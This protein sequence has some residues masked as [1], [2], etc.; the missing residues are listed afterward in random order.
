ML[1]C[2]EV[3]LISLNKPFRRWVVTAGLGGVI[4]AIAGLAF[5][6]GD[7][8]DSTPC[9]TPVDHPEWT[10]ARR[11]NEAL[12]NAIRRDVPAPTVH[13]RNLFHISA[14]MWDAW[15]AYDDDA[16]GYFV[17]E[18]L[19]AADVAAARDEAISYAAFRVLESRYLLSI[20][21]EATITEIDAL[22][23]TLCYSREVTT[24]EGDRPAA[25]G[26]RIGS[27]ILAAGLIDGA[28]EADGYLDPDYQ[29]VNPPLEVTESGTTLIDPNRWQP[30][31]LE[32]MISQNGIP[33]ENGVQEF[34]DSHWGYVTGFALPVAGPDGVP[35]DPGDPPYLGDP[36]SDQAFKDS[37]IEVI[38]YSSLL[39]PAGGVSIDISP[40]ALGANPLGTYDGNGLDVN[41]VTGTPYAPNIVNQ[42]DFGRVLA[43]FWADGPDSETPPGHWNTLANSI[44][45]DRG[46][47][48]RIGGAGEPV[49]R[50]EW[51]VKLY[52]AL[53]GANH[54]AAVAAWGTKGHYDYVRPISM[55][56]YM[57][58]L[59]QSS[60]PAGAS[61]H[62]DGLPL[63]AGLVEVVTAETTAPGQRHAALAGAEGQIAIR[64]W[65]GTPADPEEDTAGVDWM[66]AVDWVPYQKPSFVTPAFAGY[67]S[68]HSTFSRASAEVMAGF[69]GSEYFPDGLGEWT[70]AADSLEFEAGPATDITLQWATYADAADQAGISRLYGGIHVRADDLAGRIMGERIGREA[71]DLAQHYYD[72]SIAG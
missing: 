11:W 35:I 70:I 58:G 19:D 60:D 17:S 38:A 53:N 6:L 57:G 72:G 43:E 28:N 40:G 14:A 59:G 5:L 67:V 31:Q 55:I 46:S 50:L 49:D 36:E 44:S 8:T 18:K 56:R 33:I 42:A 39:D 47:D 24:T 25:L 61:Y 64:A 9:P 32:Q 4:V 34:I 37:A 20:G 45:D 16:A 12:L 62:P 1:T 29:P 51:D 22:M 2:G 21:A 15:A 27:T 13:A 30:L 48:L 65:T 23:E 26:N 10:V 69:T 41:P 3:S 71:W 63:V 7:R 68:G 54:D 52:L 66:P